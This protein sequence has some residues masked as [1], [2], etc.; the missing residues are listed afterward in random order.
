MTKGDGC[1][2][3]DFK[4]MKDKV[5]SKIDFVDNI[6]VSEEVTPANDKRAL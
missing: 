1:Q 5:I 4:V 3:G 6:S 2:Y